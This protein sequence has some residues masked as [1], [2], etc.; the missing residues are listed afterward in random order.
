MRI[1]IKALS[2]NAAWKGRRF[3]TDKY[4][5]YEKELLLKLKPMKIPDGALELWINV[6]FSSS[7]SDLDNILKPF[8]DVLQKKY[9]F[10]DNRIF[11]QVIEKCIVG[12]GEEYISFGIN[13][14]E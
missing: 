5:A 10:N 12:K 8:I 9:K 11:K 7:A 13:C 1:D 6:G 4:K 14:Y 3:K 2:V